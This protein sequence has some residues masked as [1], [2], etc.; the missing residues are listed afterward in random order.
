[1]SWLFFILWGFIFLIPQASLRVPF[2]GWELG[3]HADFILI[4]YAGFTFPFWEG[5][6]GVILVST[7]MATLSQLPPSLMIISNAILFIAIR[8]IMDRIFTEAYITKALWILPFSFLYQIL[9]ALALNPDW[10]FLGHLDSWFN[11]IF[12]GGLDI[13]MALPIFMILDVTYEVWTRI[14]S[15]K[16]ANLTGADMYQVKN[17]QRKYI[18]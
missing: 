16:K 9:N 14:F 2:F 8:A 13:I 1:M 11:F 15:S 3:L 10:A 4:I 7:L 5:L 17:A 12:Q 18:S 6:I